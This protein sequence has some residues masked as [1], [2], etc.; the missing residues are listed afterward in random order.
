MALYNLS[1]SLNTEIEISGARVSFFDKLTLNDFLIR[2]TQNDTLIYTKKAIIDINLFSY[3]DKEIKIDKISLNG[4]KIKMYEIEDDINNYS[5]LFES[6]TP[7][8]TEITISTSKPWDLFINALELNQTQIDYAIQGK[9]LSLN[10]NSI[11]GIV[12][13][14]SFDEAD[15]VLEDL[16]LDGLKVKYY[17]PPTSISSD[18]AISFPG[19][20]IN[21]SIH[22]FS[23]QSNSVSL[24]TQKNNINSKF[25]DPTHIDVYELFLEGNNFYWGDSIHANI[26]N[27][28]ATVEDSLHIKQFASE[29]A[30]SNQ[31]LKINNVQISTEASEL[32]AGGEFTY[33]DFR[34]LSSDIYQVEGS[35][36]IK[37]ANLDQKELTFFL[38]ENI[39]NNFSQNQIGAI[40]SRG[41]LSLYKGDFSIQDFSISSEDKFIV[42]GD[43]GVKNVFSID[44]PEFTFSLPYVQVKQDFIEQFFS[45]T[46]LPAELKNQGRLKAS[47]N[48]IYSSNRLTFYTLRLK[49]SQGNEIKAKGNIANIVDPE[50][51][52]FDLNFDH[53]NID[54]ST[55]LEDPSELPDEIK[56]LEKL[57]FGG[58]LK[59][60]LRDISIDGKLATSLGDLTLDANT[61]FNDDYTR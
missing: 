25:F 56:R 57:K 23:I 42:T 9:E 2:D 32:E 43:I 6:P 19:I 48:G 51:L 16:K 11:Q 20:P 3:F 7:E 47:M 44:A 54:L 53:I 41:I 52:T 29:I 58:N 45:E 34:D 24:Y 60:N 40:K 27:L 22:S 30:I 1:Q 50:N 14:M 12:D 46:D 21:L 28:T 61:V 59:G 4:S 13:K 26:K 17:N 31:A 10:A 5:F 37:K 15:Y 33:S 8:N 18:E 35:F 55:I 49:S 38:G 39:S 36:D